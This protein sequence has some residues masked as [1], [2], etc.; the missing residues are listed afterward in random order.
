MS[1]AVG[2]GGSFSDEDSTRKITSIGFGKFSKFINKGS[3]SEGGK[4][5]KG[6]RKKYKGQGKKR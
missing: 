1:K 2:K 6:Y 5:P 3:C 4:T